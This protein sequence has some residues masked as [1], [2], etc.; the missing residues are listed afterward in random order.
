MA[1]SPR[2]SSQATAA[3]LAAARSASYSSGSP[4]AMTG[5]APAAAATSVATSASAAVA[6]DV[7]QLVPRQPDVERN[8]HSPGQRH[9]VVQLQHGVAVHAQRGDPAARR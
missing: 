9:A 1:S 2:S 3:R 5:L 6:D 7:G 8:E 4:P